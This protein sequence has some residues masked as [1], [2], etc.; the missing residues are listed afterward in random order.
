VSH[1]EALQA[2]L[3]DWD[4]TLVDSAGA[5]FESYRSLFQLYGIEFDRQLYEQTYSPDWYHTYRR[6]GL[7]QAR[8]GEADARWLE[9][10]SCHRPAPLADAGD[11]L[12][13]LSAAGLRLGLVT[14]GD[15]RRVEREAAEHALDRHLSTLV[16]AGEALRPKPAPDPLLVALRRMDVMPAAAAYVG[17]SPEDVQ[18]A[19]AAGA[20]VVGVPG[21]FP[22]RSAL[23]AAT[24]DFLAHS[25]SD[26]VDHLLV[27]SVRPREL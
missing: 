1:T 18:M 24:P 26:A 10:Y 4:G 14:S 3:F 23:V 5:T 25:L 16:C 20:Y 21:G 19:R 8:W 13:R 15:R 27:R 12:T 9:F 22:N 6:V 17:D 11:A 2:V 7:P